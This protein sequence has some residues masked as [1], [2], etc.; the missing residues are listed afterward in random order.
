M[1]MLNNIWNA[2]STENME[3]IN[4]FIANPLIILEIYFIF[5]LFINLL[6]IKCTNKQKLLYLVI[7]SIGRNNK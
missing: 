3:F 2:L 1:E 4:S 5:L 7:T 6:N